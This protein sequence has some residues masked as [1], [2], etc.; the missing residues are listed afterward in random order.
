MNPTI[1]AIVVLLQLFFSKNPT[2]EEIITLIAQVGPGLA[3]AKAGQAVTIT[4]P[5]ALYGHAGTSTYSWS[6]T[7]AA[8]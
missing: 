7:T 3:N 5:E 1:S 4:F 2:V 6:P 8:P